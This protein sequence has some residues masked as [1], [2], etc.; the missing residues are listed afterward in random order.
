MASRKGDYQVAVLA[1]DLSPKTEFDLRRFCA[2]A[3]VLRSNCEMDWNFRFETAISHTIYGHLLLLSLLRVLFSHIPL[4]S[5]N[6]FICLIS[7]D[8]SI[9]RCFMFSMVQCC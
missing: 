5:A 8:L 1:F 9:E 7:M 3:L 6:A 4:S 2:V